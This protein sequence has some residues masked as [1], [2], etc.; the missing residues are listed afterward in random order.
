MCKLAT[1]LSRQLCWA[2]TPSGKG[3][4]V[5]FSGSTPSSAGRVLAQRVSTLLIID[6][7]SYPR[8]QA[9][10]SHPR[11][12]LQGEGSTGCQACPP[13]ASTLLQMPLPSPGGLLEGWRGSLTGGPAGPALKKH[14]LETTQPPR[15]ICALSPPPCSFFSSPS[16]PEPSQ[17]TRGAAQ[18]A[19]MEQAA[20]APLASAFGSLCTSVFEQRPAAGQH[21][22]LDWAPEEAQTKRKPSRDLSE[23]SQECDSFEGLHPASRGP[24][25]LRRSKKR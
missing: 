1:Y 14:P 3:K 2:Q 7:T 10:D 22:P 16:T 4:A 17:A 9:A 20:F 21:E 23:S 25:G 12:S 6:P 13:W 8:S 11:P 19:A 24:A 15:L 18:P 5:H